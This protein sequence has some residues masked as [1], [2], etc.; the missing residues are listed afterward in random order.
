MF[1]DS[2]KAICN[3]KVLA[4]IIINNIYHF[5]KSLTKSLF[6]V[7]SALTEGHAIA[8]RS[9]V[10]LQYYKSVTCLSWEFGIYK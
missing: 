6:R 10:T 1:W 9:L 3:D 4:N 7:E 5:A 2:I 8:M